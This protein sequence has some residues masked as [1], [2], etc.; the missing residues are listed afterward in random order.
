MSYTRVTTTHY[1]KDGTTISK[2]LTDHF[3]TNKPKYISKVDTIETGMAYYDLIYGIRKINAVRLQSFYKQEL[4]ETRNLKRY[5][6]VMFQQ[7]LQGMDWVTLL[8]PLE[9]KPNTMLATF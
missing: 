4:T 8:T 6:K 2:T 1:N 3:S 5:N 7:D 9:N